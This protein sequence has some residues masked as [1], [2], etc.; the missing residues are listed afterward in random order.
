M[1]RIL[2]WAQTVVS[3][4]FF[5]GAMGLGLYHLVFRGIGWTQGAYQR[6]TQL[7]VRSIEGTQKVNLKTWVVKVEGLVERPISLRFEEIQNLSR[8]IVV[9]NF[10]CV[11]GWGLDKQKW[12]GVHL[13]EIF[14]KVKINPKAKYVTFYATGG[15][16]SD[17][18]SIQEALEPDTLLA[19]KL[20]EK[21]LAP[22]NGFP[23]R[24]V[25]PRM[26]A[27]KGVKWVERIVFTEKQE[28]GYWEENGYPVDG[29]IPGWKGSS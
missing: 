21:N 20:N 7:L 14:G 8:K 19:Y 13:K 28:I 27:Y 17:S 9:K 4:R 3:R 6:V 29:S 1:D 26:Y 10:Q 18:L 12:E 22:E 15:K 23:L 11:E 24:L 5:I 2:K 16:Y 25:I